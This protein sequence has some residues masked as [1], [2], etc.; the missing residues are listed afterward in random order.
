MAAAIITAVGGRTSLAHPLHRS[1]RLLQASLAIVA[2]VFRPEYLTPVM[3]SEGALPTV[4]SISRDPLATSRELGSPLPSFPPEQVAVAFNGGKDSVVVIDLIERVIGL[5]NV[6]RCFVFCYDGP[7]EDDFE[8]LRAFR[9]HYCA[10]RGI[11]LHRLAGG[12]VGKRHATWAMYHEGGIRCAILGTRR[13][14]GVSQ[15]QPVEL[16]GNSGWPPLWRCAP[17]FEWETADIW[18]YTRSRALPNCLLYEQ[19]YSSLG[20]RSSTKRDPALVRKGGAAVAAR[21]GVP[22]WRG[23]GGST[24][25]EAASVDRSDELLTFIPAWDSPRPGDRVARL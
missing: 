17:V 1:S 18:G 8:E 21:K 5:A 11:S 7:E 25:P 4:A 23:E 16:G 13:S 20:S 9:D 19:G 14:D 15:T 10:T 6:R 24:A 22:A 12:A 2:A 3:A